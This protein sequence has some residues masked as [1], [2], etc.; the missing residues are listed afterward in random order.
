MVD[1]WIAL[2]RPANHVIIT[3]LPPRP[4]GTSGPIPSLNAGIRSRFGAK[5][6]RVLSLDSF[7]SNDAGLTWKSSCSFDGGTT[8]CQV[9]DSLHY[10]EVVRNWIADNVV[11]IMIA[12]P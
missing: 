9:G 3:T 1:Q 10:S 12:T 4:S 11:Q 8:A 6:A 2:G 5:G 7:V